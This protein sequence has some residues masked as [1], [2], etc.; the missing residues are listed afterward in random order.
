MV[1]PIF[2][3]GC[4]TNFCFRFL[5]FVIFSYAFLRPNKTCYCDNFLGEKFNSLS[6]EEACPDCRFR[7][8]LADVYECTL[9]PGPPRNFV[10]RN[11]T[12]MQ[13]HLSWDTSNTYAVVD[14]YLIEAKVLGT[15][16]TY[17][18]NPLKLTY[19]NNTYNVLLIS[20]HP[21]TKYNVSVQAMGSKGPGGLAHQVITTE[22]GGK[23]LLSLCEFNLV[24]HY[25]EIL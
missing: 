13:A 17:K 8:N 4:Y 24:Y 12:D 2:F 14:H 6:C 15:Y 9:V 22:I 20:L 16:S 1:V 5:I 25:K 10:V 19:S 3:F 21:G 23:A 7:N 18:I 11:V